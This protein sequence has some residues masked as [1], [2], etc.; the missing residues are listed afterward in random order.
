[1]ENTQSENEWGREGIT[2]AI[3]VK[4]EEAGIKSALESFLDSRLQIH[5]LLV[6]GGVKEVLVWDTGSTDGTVGLVTEHY[7][8]YANE[9]CPKGRLETRLVQSAPP[10]V[11]PGIIHFGDARNRLLE[12]AEYDRVI[13]LDGDEQITVFPKT[14]GVGQLVSAS[15]LLDLVNSGKQPP[16]LDFSEVTVETRTLR[17]FARGEH[18]FLLADLA[19]VARKSPDQPWTVDGSLLAQIRGV[20]RRRWK[21]EWPIHNRPVLKSGDPV[22]VLSYSCA[23]SR[24]GWVAKY[25]PKVL[26]SERVEAVYKEWIPQLAWTAMNAGPEGR[27][28]ALDAL[29]AHSGYLA[30]FRLMFDNSEDEYGFKSSQALVELVRRSL[31]ELRWLSDAISSLQPDD[32]ER[33]LV[34][35]KGKDSSVHTLE[36]GCRAL[37]EVGLEGWALLAVV[38]NSA[39]T[40][41]AEYAAATNA[42]ADKLREELRGNLPRFV[43]EA[44]ARR[45]L[46]D[47]ISALTT[48]IAYGYPINTR[49][50]FTDSVVATAFLVESVLCVQ[51]EAAARDVLDPNAYTELTE[52]Y[53]GVLGVRVT[54]VYWEETLKVFHA[55]T[56]DGGALNAVVSSVVRK[57]QAAKA[58][59]PLEA[60]SRP[61]PSV[62]GAHSPRASSELSSL[63]L[64]RADRRAAARAG[65]KARV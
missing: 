25:Q 48:V 50:V 53:P 15:V 34:K 29:V 65:R 24:L 38:T 12:L 3:M 10:E 26:R 19:T 45:D 42:K 23:R 22:D 30:K 35:L 31:N 9:S 11:A 63:P 44:K 47:S 54:P 51:L 43:E 14:S 21:Y 59:K 27:L 18:S 32:R 52:K 56:K 20:C 8:R 60:S 62:R 4:N 39:F 1:M 13:L 7:S 28:S 5:D 16:K 57:L 49:L 6:Q 58:G 36:A 55:C 41:A 64:S 33:L 40:V 17:M 2:I 61:S 37:I 46:L